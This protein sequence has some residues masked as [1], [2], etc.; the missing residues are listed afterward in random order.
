MSWLGRMWTVASIEL[1]QRVRGLAW[2]VLLG[3]FVVVVLLVTVFT[4]IATWNSDA[5]GAVL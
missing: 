1:Q 3:V 4:T 5:P 2:Y